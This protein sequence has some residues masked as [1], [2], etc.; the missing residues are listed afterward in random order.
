MTSRAGSLP[1]R[2]WSIVALASAGMTAVIFSYLLAIVFA[3]G[4]LALP[5]L[6]L[7]AFPVAEGGNIASRILISAFS[8]VVALTILWS[9]IPENPPFDANGVRVDL[10]RQ[11]RLAAEIQTIADTLREP[12]PSEVFVVADAN[13]FV[14]EIPGP[15]GKRRILALG[16]PL[17]QMLSIAQFRAV[18]AH[19][20]GHYYAGDTR[21]G[22]SVYNTRRAMYRVYENLGR[23]SKIMSFL[24]RWGVISALYSLLMGALRMYWT[25]FMRI[26]QAI[27]RR[28]EIR[29]D[30]LACHIAGSQALIDGLETIRKCSAG[31]DAYWTSFVIPIAKGG[32]QP[33]LAVGF[34]QF[35]RAPHVEKAMAEFVTQQSTVETASPFDSH[36]PLGKRIELARLINRPAPERSTSE[37]SL[38]MISLIDDLGDVQLAIFRKV[39]PEL[40]TAELKPLDWDRAGSDVYIPEWHKDVEPFL[41]FLTTKKMNDLPLLIL[42]PRPIAQLV[43]NPTQGRI[44]LAQK[45]AIAVDV[46]FSAFTLTLIANGWKLVTSPGTLQL[47]SGEKNIDPAA[48]IGSLQSGDLS[49]IDWKAFRAAHDIGDWPLAGPAH[50]NINASAPG[51]ADL[52]VSPA[53]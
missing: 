39:L 15:N 21:L 49:V 24:R 41:P 20:F 25:V 1:S 31:L 28:Q 45:M 47:Q 7:V 18:L 26:T 10:A 40:Q 42:D 2:K 8:I 52:V 37:I 53:R 33:D 38:P 23:K 5:V 12:M 3:I 34:Q 9:L 48:V 27:S 19:E 14:T 43:P 46:L 22:P 11:P 6:L 36:P 13:A 50:T 16:L 17:L 4:C 35:M 29:S 44:N 32:Y 30:E 51:A